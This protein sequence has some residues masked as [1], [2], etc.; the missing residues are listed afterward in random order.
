MGRKTR[1]KSAQRTESDNNVDLQSSTHDI[2]Y[3][4]DDSFN[5]RYDY[6]IDS[7]WQLSSPAEFFREDIPTWQDSELMSMKS[8]LNDVKGRLSNVDIV[9]WQNHTQVCG[10]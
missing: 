9:T 3:A 10:N 4:I 2:I 8:R 6:R 5:R 1:R 7:S